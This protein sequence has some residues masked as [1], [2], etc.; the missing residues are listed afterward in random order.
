[1]TRPST[2]ARN[3]LYEAYEDRLDVNPDLHRSLVS[4]QGNKAAPFYRWFKYKEGFSSQLV[5]Y[6][7]RKLADG[8]GTLL[9]PFAGAGAALFASRDLGW[10]AIGIELLPTAVYAIEVRLAAMAVRPEKFVTAAKKMADIDFK[11][12]AKPDHA[13]RHIT[14]T[15]GAFSD[16]TEEQLAGYLRYCKERVRDHHVRR[17]LEFASFCVL[18]EVSYTRKDGQ[19]LRWDYRSGRNG[20]ARQFN[21]GRIPSFGKAVRRKIAVMAEDIAGSRPLLCE[22]GRPL[23]SGCLDIRSG[24]CL[25]LLPALPGE[26]VDFVMT[27]PPYCNRYDYTRTYALELAFLGTDDA[28][29]KRLRQEMLSC[30]V[31]NRAKTQRLMKVYDDLGATARLATIEAGFASQDALQEVLQAL[32]C[33]KAAGDLNNNNI[34]RMVENYFREMCFCIAEMTRAL[35]PGGVLVMVNDNV[36]YAG[37]EVPVD[38]ILSAFAEYF[39]LTVRHIWVLPRGKG[40]SSQ[41]MGNHGRRELRKCVYV[42]EKLR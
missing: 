10:N 23:R 39:G 2:D 40:N 38:L 15:S 18:E 9:D 33:H 20:S 29:V 21:K 24:S 11:E 6:C 17:L 35:R 19:Y 12:L 14:I 32:M 8:P 27:S 13:F 26:T 30:T 25:E 16:S 36:R 28:A 42:W 34:P 22:T 41:Q 31:E 3:A 37:E 5:D 1:M 4:F 7:L